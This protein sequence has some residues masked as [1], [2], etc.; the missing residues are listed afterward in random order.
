MYLHLYEGHFS[1][2]TD[3]RRLTHSW[4]CSRCD[5]FFN[6][7]NDYH[8][9]ELTCDKEIEHKFKGGGVGRFSR[10]ALLDKIEETTGVRVPKHLKY[11]PYKIAYDF[12]T[13]FEKCDKQDGPKLS[14]ENVLVPASVSVCSDVPGYEDPKCF[15]SEGDPK[16]MIIDM[17]NY[18]IEIADRSYEILVRS[19]GTSWT[20]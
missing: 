15:I 9:H 8:Q 19:T 17:Y 7:S 20:S 4:R 3:I 2:I 1:Y 14:Y 10:V 6:R 5:K 12:E 11:F 13:L 18:M 16:K